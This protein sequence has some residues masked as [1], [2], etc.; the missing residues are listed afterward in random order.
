MP[1]PRVDVILHQ[2]KPFKTYNK[3]AIVRCGLEIHNYMAN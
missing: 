1:A 3:P 2:N